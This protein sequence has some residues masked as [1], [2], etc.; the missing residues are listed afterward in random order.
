VR[1]MLPLVLALTLVGGGCATAL[2][3]QDESLRKPY[4]GFTMHLADFYGGGDFGELSGILFW[5]VWLVDKPLSLAADTVT[6][7]YTLW[8]QRDTWFPRKDPNTPS[9]KADGINDAPRSQSYR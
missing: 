2:N 7:P 9:D 4:G 6:L 5:P 8:V 1:R 3:L